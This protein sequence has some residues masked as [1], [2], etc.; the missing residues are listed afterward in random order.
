MGF[1]D[2][3]G[4][5]VMKADVGTFAFEA[6]RVLCGLERSL[7]VGSIESSSGKMVFVVKRA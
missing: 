2:L 5:E 1:K 4:P 6:R 3:C 7:W